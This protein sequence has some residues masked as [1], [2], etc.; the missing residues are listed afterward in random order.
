MYNAAQIDLHTASVVLKQEHSI[1][2]FQYVSYIQRT[3]AE[4]PDNKR[5]SRAY[6]RIV[7]HNCGPTIRWADFK[8]DRLYNIPC[9]QHLR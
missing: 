7:P 1:S 4:T 9:H 2:L 6:V 3:T 8:V 5:L